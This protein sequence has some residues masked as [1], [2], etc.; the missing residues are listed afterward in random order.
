MNIEKYLKVAKFLDRLNGRT[1]KKR[2]PIEIDLHFQ[3]T[4]V[5]SSIFPVSLLANGRSTI[6]NTFMR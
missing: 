1:K 2:A 4:E 3:A 6:P 5:L